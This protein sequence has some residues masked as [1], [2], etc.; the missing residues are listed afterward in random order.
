MTSAPARLALS[1]KKQALHL[2]FDDIGITTADPLERDAEAY[3]RWLESGKHGS[4]E[5][6]ARSGE[7]RA[8]PGRILPGCRSVVCVAVNHFR[9]VSEETPPGEGR[10]ARYG[11]GRDYHRVLDKPM[12]RL[13]K[14]IRSLGEEVQTKWCLD[15]SHVLERGFAARAGIGFQGKNTMLISKRLGSHLFLGEIFTTLALAPDEPEPPRCGTC[16]RCLDACPTGAFPK[17]WVLDATRCIS[18]WTIEHRGPLP[19]DAELHGWVFGCDICQDVCPWNR[20]ARPTDASGLSEDAVAPTLNLVELAELDQTEF[21]IQFY[22]T[23][24][25]RARREGLERNARANLAFRVIP[26]PL[27][28]GVE[29]LA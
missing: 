5:Y 13:A 11:L 20:F 1:V 29:D 21:E 26:P 23:A 8:D 22:G 28:S 4:M 17:P 12:K 10:V 18:Y 9:E 3:E 16:T 24:L 2:G 25:W 15:T 14:F 7:K 27:S 19:R 6:M